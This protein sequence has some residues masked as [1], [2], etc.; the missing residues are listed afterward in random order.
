MSTVTPNI[1][2]APPKRNLVEVLVAFWPHAVI[3]VS[4][5]I[6]ALAPSLRQWAASHPDYIALVGAVIALA[7]SHTPT[8]QSRIGGSPTPP[9]K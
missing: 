8:P 9:P 2:G 3:T 5:I 7:A 4:A 6:T 1:E